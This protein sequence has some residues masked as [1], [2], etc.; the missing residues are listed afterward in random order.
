MND[1]KNKN[2][3]ITGASSG[4]GSNL[5]KTFAQYKCNII[6]LSRNSD[7]MSSLISTIDKFDGQVLTAYKLDVSIEEDVIVVFKKIIERF[8]TVDVLIN[9]AGITSDNLLITMK[10]EQWNNV[11]NTNLNGCY[12]CSKAISRQMIKQKSGKIINISSIIGQ[13]GNK[14]Q[15]NYA[16][17][18]AGIIGLTKSLAKELASR[19]INV[20]AINPGY[21]NTKMTEDLSNKDDFLKN[22]PLNRYGE[23]SDVAHLACFLASEKSNYITGQTI[24]VDGGMIM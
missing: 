5:V 20:N 13:V 10:T 22:I 6:L 11:I 9:N 3:I 1:L 4:I 15:S 24:N 19:K 14:G 18:K 16:A 21:I 17:S 8:N 12:Y 7:K 23:P 2:I